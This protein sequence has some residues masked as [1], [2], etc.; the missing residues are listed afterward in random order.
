MQFAP[1][2]SCSAL[3]RKHSKREKTVNYCQHG[4]DVYSY[5][6]CI[7][8]T[9]ENGTPIYNATKYSKTTSAHQNACFGSDVRTWPVNVII[10]RDV[11]RGASAADL[12]ALAKRRLLVA[13]AKDETPSKRKGRTK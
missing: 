11:P 10:L 5:A 8:T 13:N 2:V 9:N 1:G 7:R 3:V 12:R 6:T 4:E